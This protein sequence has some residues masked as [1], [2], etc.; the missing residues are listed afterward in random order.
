MSVLC[1]IFKRCMVQ[2]N[3]IDHTSHQYMN[4][5][6]KMNKLVGLGDIVAAHGIKG[7]VKIRT[8]TTDPKDIMKYGPLLDE[9]GQKVC[10]IKSVRESSPHLVIA[11]LENCNTRNEAELF[12]GKKLF[13]YREQLPAVAEDEF[14]H[15]DLVGMQ[16][17]DE[18]GSVLGNILGLQDFGAGTFIDVQPLDCN[19]IS[20]IP[21]TKDAILSVDTI[22]KQMV[23]NREFVLS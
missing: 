16:V 15:E 22:T 23:V 2:V 6:H 14:Y 21:F 4:G 3:K 5:L 20:T 12:M 19:K 11:T 1:G 8:H 7:Q 13:I 18:D 17:V 10:V 9:T